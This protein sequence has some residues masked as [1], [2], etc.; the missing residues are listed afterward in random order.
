MVDTLVL[1]TS[2]LQC[3]G[4]NPSFGTKSCYYGD[5]DVALMWVNVFDR[6]TL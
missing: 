2:T 4:S 3:E 1:G 5:G 6:T